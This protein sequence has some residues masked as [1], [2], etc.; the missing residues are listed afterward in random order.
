MSTNQS[1]QL[2][3]VDQ[4]EPPRPYTPADEKVEKGMAYKFAAMKRRT[5]GVGASLT[6][7]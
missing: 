4:S 2:Y 3:S 1:R 6:L 5:A 7:A